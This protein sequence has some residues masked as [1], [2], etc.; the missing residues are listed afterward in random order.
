MEVFIYPGYDNTFLRHDVALARLNTPVYNNRHVQSIC[1]PH[2]A[3]MY[4]ASGSTCMATG[5]GDLSE[6]GPS[7]E[8]LR[9]VEVPILAKC[10]RSYNNVSYQIC[11]GF[12]EG[13]KDACQG[14][15]GGPLYCMDSQ[16]SWYLGGVISHG[17]GCARAEEAGVYVRLAY[18][19]EW[20]RQVMSGVVPAVGQPRQ[21]CGG[22]KCGSGECVPSKWV[23]DKTVDCLDGGDVLGCVTLDNGTRVQVLEEV[24]TAPE[25]SIMVDESDEFLSGL[26]SL[27]DVFIWTSVTCDE[28]QF[29]CSSLEQCV[30]ARARCDGVRDCPDWSDEMDCRCGELVDLAKV[31][32][33]VADCRDQSDEVECD[34]CGEEEWRCPLSGECVEAG[35]KCDTYV[36]CRWGE[37]E[38]YCTALTEDSYLPLSPTGDVI[39]NHQGMLLI[40]QKQEW[41]PVCAAGFSNS[42]AKN[43]CQYMGWTGSIKYGLVPPADS[44]LNASDIVA[45]QVQRRSATNCFHVNME[46]EEDI[47]GERPMYRNLQYGTTPPLSGPGSWPWHAN[48][49]NEGGIYLRGHYFTQEVRANRHLLC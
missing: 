8:L 37:D 29:K 12:A 22:V 18:Y 2:D 20:V 19:M 49:F 16:E 36:D 40:N 7:S 30:P 21:E 11:G 42:L 14:D 24:A 23:C 43:I 46:C 33:G 38:R 39:P 26:V 10:G 17:R 35:T 6:D 15:S 4:P 3:N 32:D 44:P 27:S 34:M 41:K 5:W 47:C 1:L 9:E 45:T 28:D 25:S 31:C 13:G 48:I